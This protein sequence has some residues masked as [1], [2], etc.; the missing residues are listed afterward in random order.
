MSNYISDDGFARIVAEEVKNKTSPADKQ[1]LLQEHNWE[2]WRDA[3]IALSQNLQEQIESIEADAMAD[4]IRYEAMGSSGRRLANEAANAYSSRKIKVSRF[5]FHVDK[6]LDE[7][8]VMIETGK[9]MASDGWQ[10][11][12]FLRKGISAHRALMREYD[13]EPT[14]IDRALWATLDNKWNFDSIDTDSL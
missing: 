5:K 6:R 13:L 8:T 7:V 11:V 1:M 2:R 10:N 4:K 14:A 12:E 3:L 9:V